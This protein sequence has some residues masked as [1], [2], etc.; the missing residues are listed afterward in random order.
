M[1]KGVLGLSTCVELGF[2]AILHDHGT[3]EE[4]SIQGSEKTSWLILRNTANDALRRIKNKTFPHLGKLN[5]LYKARNLAQHH[6]LAP[7]TQDLKEFVEPV[8]EI[9]EIICR[10]LYGLDF[11]RL[12]EWDALESAELKEWFLASARAIEL[13]VPMVSVA[14]S[15]VAYRRMI[16]CVVEVAAPPS[17]HMTGLSVGG[18]SLPPGIRGIVEKLDEAILDQQ[19]GVIAVSL[20]FSIAD[21]YK[22]LRSGLGLHVQ[23]A[24]G[25]KIWLTKTGRAAA[26]SISDIEREDTFML[27]YLGRAA[28]YLE[29]TFPGV[30]DGPMFKVPL[31]EQDIWPSAKDSTKKA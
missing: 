10:D 16:R 5:S 25:G 19:A 4:Q 26:Q 20:G 30:F 27:D 8:R 29:S 12:R 21:H 15:K 17:L 31:M 23:V 1:M 22:F 7:N 9:L 28:F 2:N 11:E 18:F 6:G 24:I 14:A 13:G 3:P